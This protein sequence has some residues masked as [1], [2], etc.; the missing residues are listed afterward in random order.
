MRIVPG[1]LALAV[2]AT[3]GKHFV[4]SFETTTQGGPYSELPPARN[5]RIVS[6][7]GKASTERTFLIDLAR[8]PPKQR[9]EGFDVTV[10]DQGTITQVD[11]LY[12]PS[13]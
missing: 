12:V 3:S 7:K 8:I 13:W 11:W 5:S 4:Q 9:D 10:D 6:A 1:I 2:A